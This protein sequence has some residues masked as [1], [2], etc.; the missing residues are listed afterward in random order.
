M[1]RADGMKIVVKS[2]YI[3]TAFRFAYAYSLGTPRIIIGDHF[4]SY[5]VKD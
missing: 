5:I 1:S 2:S 3:S 4:L